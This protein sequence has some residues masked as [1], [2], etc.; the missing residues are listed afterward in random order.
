[1]NYGYARVS[2]VD[3]NLE[4]QIFELKNFGIG[5]KF[6]YC[7]KKSGKDFCRDAYLKLTRKIK[8]GDLLVVKSI[9]RLGRNYVMI[10]NEWNRITNVIGANILV[11]DMPILDT[12]EKNNGLMGKFI[13]DVVLQVLSF[14]AENERNNIKIRQRE[15]IAIAHKNGVKFGRPKRVLTIEELNSLKNYNLGLLTLR[16]ALAINKMKSALFYYYLKKYRSGE[17][18]Y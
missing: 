12:R 13:S 3:Q 17:Y 5:E 9:D 16:Q 15:G 7:D 1:M 18:D 10:T 4:R 8:K 6:I 2:T 11:L 14:V